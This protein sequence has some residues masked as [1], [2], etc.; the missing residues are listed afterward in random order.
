MREGES[1]GRGR[2]RREGASE[3]DVISYPQAADTHAFA[4]DSAA[5]GRSRVGTALTRPP[6]RCL[7]RRAHLLPRGPTEVP[8]SSGRNRS[9]SSSRSASA[10]CSTRRVLGASLLSRVT[11]RDQSTAFHSCT[12]LNATRNTFESRRFDASARASTSA[13]SSCIMSSSTIA[14][15][16][17]SVLAGQWFSRARACR[18]RTAGSVDP[19]ARIYMARTARRISS[20]RSHC[21][22]RARSRRSAFAS[23]ARAADLA[24][25]R[26]SLL[27]SN[28]SQDGLDIG[29][30]V[31]R[32]RLL[33]TVKNL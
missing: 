5:S 3:A 31:L 28:A 1:G 19:S 14:D 11:R 12:Y 13:G 26:T 33:D 10:C 23:S 29:Q 7:N 27:S 16:S 22:A 2:K 24:L 21:F 20:V 18:Y 25:L 17:A 8:I 30:R 9:D 6:Q 4:C 15:S 32:K